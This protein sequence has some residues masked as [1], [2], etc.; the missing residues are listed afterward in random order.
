MGLLGG[1]RAN[2]SGIC[3]A[4]VPAARCSHS[5]PPK[6]MLI[7]D[8]SMFPNPA[9]AVVAKRSR[10]LSFAARAKSGR[11]QTANQEPYLWHKMS[12]AKTPN[13]NTAA[14]REVELACHRLCDENKLLMD[15]IQ[16]LEAQVPNP[17][18]DGLDRHVFPNLFAF[19]GC[20]R[21]ARA[22]G[23]IVKASSQAHV[24][25]DQGDWK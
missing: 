16:V 21:I 12:R 9:Q 1:L 15:T 3:D 10:S 20:A 23:E 14:L 13:S 7:H 25:F 6:P 19:M 18:P 2:V 22:E 4:V 8:V 11:S 17:M 24:T 5:P